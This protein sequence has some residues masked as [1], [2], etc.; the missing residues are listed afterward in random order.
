MR[1]IMLLADRANQYV[2][3]RKPWALAK[4]PTR[5]AEVLG[6]TTQGLNLF[7]VLMSLLAPVLP[8][9]AEEAGHFLHA[10]FIDWNDIALPLL[11]TT[12]APYQPLATRL[13]PKIVS[14]LVEPAPVPA[15][16][17]VT[18]SDPTPASHSTLIKID[19]FQKLDLR[20]ARI[21]NAETVEGSD[22][23]LR[24][25]LDLGSEQRNVLSGIRA[26]YE[27][28]AL[29]GR[30]VLMVANLEPRKMRFGVSEGMVLCA[31]GDGP[32]LYL[33]SPDIGAM[34]GMKVT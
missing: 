2:D 23:L 3:T 13:E 30:M 11:G 19:D 34:A 33:L 25:S 27:P 5:A 20:I 29:V 8:K 28:Q 1:E 15:P 24:L 32:G 9:M 18:M 14:S 21:V 22:K 26:A 31:S 6:I 10:P 16:G 17:A 4:D 7:R 12:I